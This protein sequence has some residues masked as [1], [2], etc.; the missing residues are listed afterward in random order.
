M[1]CPQVT[2]NNM[3]ISVQTELKY[4][5]LY[6]DQKLTWQKHVKTERQNLNLKLR[7]MSWLLGHKSKLS[8]EKKLLLYECT[9]EPTWTYGIQLWGCVKPSNTKII[10]IS[11]QILALSNPTVSSTDS[12]CYAIAYFLHR[13]LSPL[14][15]NIDSSAKNS[16]HFTK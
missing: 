16:I 14:A 10:K 11:I 12:P 7:E 2:M 9:I 1:T 13:I 6:L 8:I 15:G 4:V 5:G 3:Q